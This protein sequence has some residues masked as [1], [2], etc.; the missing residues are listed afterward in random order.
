[1]VTNARTGLA[2]KVINIFSLLS[3][4]LGVVGHD[5]KLD[6]DLCCTLLPLSQVCHCTALASKT[7]QA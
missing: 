3:D 4:N 5:K 7:G 1:M 2:I 6:K